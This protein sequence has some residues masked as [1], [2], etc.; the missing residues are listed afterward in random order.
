[1]M[2]SDPTSSLLTFAWPMLIFL[3]T[4]FVMRVSKADDAEEINF[5]ELLMEEGGEPDA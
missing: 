4:V 1:M 2:G 3:V 5:D